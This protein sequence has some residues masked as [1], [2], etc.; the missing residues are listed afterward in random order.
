[1]SDAPDCAEAAGNLSRSLE[2]LAATAKA[3]ARSQ[4]D[5]AADGMQAEKRRYMWMLISGA[6]MVLW[7][8]F[9]TVFVGVAIVI[10]FWETHRMLAAALVA[11]GFLVLAGVAAWVLCHNWRRRPTAFEWIGGMLAMLAQYRRP[12]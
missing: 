2:R 10:A 7:L 9:G 5:R 1:V 8:S 11:A 3:Y 4:L 12:R 6:A